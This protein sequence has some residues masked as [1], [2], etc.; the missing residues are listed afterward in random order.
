M[1]HDGVYHDEVRSCPHT[2]QKSHR[3]IPW[4]S[5]GLGM[6]PPSYSILRCPLPDHDPTVFVQVVFPS[7]PCRIFLK[8]RMVTLPPSLLPSL[9]PSLF[10][11]DQ[12]IIGPSVL[13]CY[14]EYTSFHFGLCCSIFLSDPKA[15]GSGAAS[16]ARAGPFFY[17]KKL[18]QKKLT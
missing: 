18:T 14:V 16:T 15:A 13:V 17:I 8:C 10:L 1:I 9:P 3:S 6:L 12:N 7:F 2:R 5:E 4:L 11:S